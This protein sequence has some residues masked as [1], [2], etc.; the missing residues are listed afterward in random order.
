MAKRYVL[1]DD[2]DTG[3]TD[4]DL[5]L[6][7]LY[8]STTPAPNTTPSARGGFRILKFP[9]DAYIITYANHDLYDSLSAATLTLTGSLP[10]VSFRCKVTISAVAGHT[11]VAGS[12]VVGSE[13]LDFLAAG[14]KTTTTALSAL[15]IIT[16]SGLDCNILVEAITTGG[17]PI[18]AETATA[19]KIQF[20]NTSSG[21]FNSQG[22]WTVY[23]GSYA[24]CRDAAA[25][26]DK[27]RYGGADLPIKKVDTEK[28]FSKILYYI[29]YL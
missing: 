16:T 1:V 21:Y 7:P 26:G 25:V 2:T 15:P 6:G 27:L 4:L 19:T 10:S 8:D 12:V 13:T 29:F 14:T 9:E 24:M 23:S 3:T 22:Q 11:D 28:W 17:A 20:E 18:Q 5:E